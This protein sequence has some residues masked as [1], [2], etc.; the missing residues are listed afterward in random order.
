MLY[1]LLENAAKT[2]LIN[3]MTGKYIQYTLN[4]PVCCFHFHSIENKIMF[5]NNKINKIPAGKM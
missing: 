5:S 4:L 1:R 3:L 2:V